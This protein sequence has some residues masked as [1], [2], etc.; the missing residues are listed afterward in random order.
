MI[1]PPS[2]FRLNKKQHVLNTDL[3]TSRAVAVARKEGL[4]D[5]GLADVV[6]SQLALDGSTVFT[7]YHLGRAFTILRHPVKLATSL[8]YYRRVAT[9]EPS[10]RPDYL[11]ITLRDF[12]EMEGYYDNWMV[13]S[14][15][16]CSFLCCRRLPSD[17][18]LLRY[19]FTHFNAFSRRSSGC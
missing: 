15:G 10:Y 6:V 13:V 3:S 12:A 9:W 17:L 5:R 7:P 2:D 4:V 8:F 1:S 19:A 14:P 16:V 11:D 18:H